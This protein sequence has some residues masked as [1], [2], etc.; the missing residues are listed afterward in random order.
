M[1]GRAT[2]S[3]PRLTVPL[4]TWIGDVLGLVGGL[5]ATA[6]FTHMTPYAY[7]QATMEAITPTIFSQASSRL[8]LGLRSD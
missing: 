7:I 3:R 1:A 8:R 4:L 6:I 2:L 5:G